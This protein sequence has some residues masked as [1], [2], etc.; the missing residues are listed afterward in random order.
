MSVNCDQKTMNVS[1]RHKSANTNALY[2]EENVEMHIRRNKSL[3]FADPGEHKKKK[4]RKSRKSK[5][6]KKKRRS[7]VVAVQAPV[8]AVAPP[9]A[10]TSGSLWIKYLSRIARP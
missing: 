2:Q 5:K 6:S 8:A 1:G 4:R 3:H 10:A 9:S 7:S